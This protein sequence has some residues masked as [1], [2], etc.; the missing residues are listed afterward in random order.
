MCFQFENPIDAKDD[1]DLDGQTTIAT[2]YSI[3]RFRIQK[4]ISNH[5]FTVGHYSIIM[6]YPKFATFDVRWKHT[7]YNF[8][9][10]VL[11]K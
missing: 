5:F 11:T 7:I 4:P 9:R 6:Y 3:K 1:V 8:W 2:K 10:W